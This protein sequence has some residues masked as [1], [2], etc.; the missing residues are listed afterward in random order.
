M[1]EALCKPVS[2]ECLVGNGFHRGELFDGQRKRLSHAETQ[3]PQ[4]FQVQTWPF[5]VIFVALCEIKSFTLRELLGES[6][7]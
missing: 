1:L 7:G 3:S 2:D 4:G 6:G 5:S